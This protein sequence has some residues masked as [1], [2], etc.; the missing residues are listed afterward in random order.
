MQPRVRNLTVHPT[1]SDPALILSFIYPP[2][3]DA[4]GP[5][6]PDKSGDADGPGDQAH[7]PDGH[8]DHAVRQHVPGGPDRAAQGRLHR[9]HGAQVRAQLRPREQLVA[10][11]SNIL[12]Q[13]GEK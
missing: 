9:T 8:E 13:I 11:K 5:Q 12:V 4:R 2:A 7:H 1:L 10:G 6:Q 3:V